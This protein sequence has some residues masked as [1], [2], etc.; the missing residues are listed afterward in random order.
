MK[1]YKEA[2]PI[3]TSVAIRSGIGE[4]RSSYPTSMKTNEEIVEEFNSKFSRDLF[5]PIHTK[6]V[7]DDW[8]RTTLEAKDKE[9]EE[10][11]REE[12]EMVFKE[13]RDYLV[14]EQ[15]ASLDVIQGLCHALLTP[16]KTDKT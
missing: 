6:P 15:N 5:A 3:N 11:V 14:M 16:T 2:P 13:A 4:T 10:R 1:D 9:C 7:I 8:L 12:R